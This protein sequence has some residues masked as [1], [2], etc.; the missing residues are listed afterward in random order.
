MPAPQGPAAGVSMDGT[1]GDG[2][3]SGN[4]RTVGNDIGDQA[5]PPSQ[6]PGTTAIAPIELDLS[7]NGI[8][9][10]QLTSSNTF[11]AINQDGY[12][13]RTAWAGAGDAVLFVDPNGLDTIRDANQYIFTDWD[14]SA[15]TDMQAL[16]DVFDTNHDGSLDAGDA[17]FGEFK[18]MV[19]NADGTTS[20]ETLAQAGISS[21][22]L[23]ASTVNQSFADGSSIDGETTFTRTDGSTGT[24]AAVT[25]AAD[26]QGYAVQNTTTVGADGTTTIDNRALNAD[27]SLNNDTSSATSAD[28]ATRTISYDSNGV[29]VIDHVQT[30]V[31]STDAQGDTVLT[32][33]DYDGQNQLKDST[34]TTT[35]AD[36]STVRIARDL[37]G[38]GVINQIETRQTNPDDSITD[39]LTDVNADHS[40]IDQTV[41]TSFANG[42]GRKT[43]VDSTGDG[44]FDRTTQDT[45]VVNGDGSRTE[46]ISTINAD[47][48][49]ITG[50]VIVT[51]AD[52]LTRTSSID[53]NGDLT[54]DLTRV[55]QTTDNAD[56]SVTTTTTELNGDTSVRDVTAT[57]LSAVG[58]SKTNQVDLNGD[59]TFDRTATDITATN[60]RGGQTED[61]TTTS[62]DGTL[63]SEVL[64]ARSTDGVSRNTTHYDRSGDVLSSDEIGVGPQGA[65]VENAATFGIDGTLLHHTLKETSADGLTTTT[66]TDNA[67][68]GTYDRIVV[69][70][71]IENGNGSATEVAGTRSADGTLLGR[72]VIGTSADGLTVVTRADSTGAQN[73]DG[74]G[75]FDRTTTDSTSYTN[76][77]SRHRTVTVTSANGALLSA[78]STD[79]AADRQSHSVTTD[80]N[81]DGYTTTLEQVSTAAGGA[82][83]DSITDLNPD[84]S[85]V[86]D[87][88]RTTSANGLSITTQIDASGDG[89]YN[90]TTTDNTTIGNDGL[91]REVVTNTAYDSTV[92][93]RTVMLSQANGMSSSMRVDTTGDGTFDHVTNTGKTYNTDGSTTVAVTDKAADRSTRD[94][95]V[96][97]T[98][99]DGLS[100][101][102]Q[103]D[104]DG[105]GSFD[106]TTL[107]T[108]V[109]EANGDVTK[110]TTDMNGDGSGDASAVRDRTASTMSGD[111]RSMTSQ[112]EY[113]G[114]VTFCK[115]ENNATQTNGD[116]SDT[117]ST[118]ASPDGSGA[119]L[120]T[121]AVTTSG[122][123]LSKTTQ[124]DVNG[125]GTFDT[126]ASDVTVFAA[127]GDR[128]ETMTTSGSAGMNGQTVVT[129]S[130]NGLSKTVQSDTAGNGTVD[131]TTH[132]DTT[133]NADGSRREVYQ[134]TNQDGSLRNSTTTTTS[135]D[136]KHVSVTRVLGGDGSQ[137]ET[138]DRGL[139][140]TVTDVL[141]AMDAMAMALGAETVA[142]SANGLTKTATYTDAGGNVQDTQSDTRVL[143]DDGSTTEQFS[144]VNAN[145]NITAVFS[146]NTSGNGL[147][148]TTTAQFSNLPFVNY[149]TLDTTTLNNDGTLNDTITTSNADGST[150]DQSVRTVSAD[151]L[152]ATSSLDDNADGNAE[153]T[154]TKVTATD[155]SSVRTTTIV[156]AATHA[157]DRQDIVT[158][159]ADGRT[160]TLQSARDG[161][162]TIRYTET[163]VVNPNGTISDK[164]QF[165]S[166]SAAPSYT[167]IRSQTLDTTGGQTVAISNYDAT[168]G[169]QDKTSTTVSGNGLS[170]QS[171]LDTTGDG[172]ADQIRTDDTAI[173]AD[174]SRTE[175]VS[176]TLSPNLAALLGP[177]LAYERTINASADGLTVT[178]STD[179]DGNGKS[180]KTETSVRG[181]NGSLTDTVTFND[182]TTGE[183]VMAL[184]I[185]GTQSAGIVK[186]TSA[187]GLVVS[188][189]V[190]DI[191]AQR[192]YVAGSNGSYN[193]TNS[194]TDE[195][196]SPNGRQFASASHSVDVNGVDT[197]TSSYRPDGSFG[198]VPNTTTTI[199]IDTAKEQA[200]VAEANAIYQTVLNRPMMDAEQESLIQYIQGGILDQQAL[201]KSLVGPVFFDTDFID[202][203]YANDFGHGPSAS[204]VAAY[205]NEIHQ[206]GEDRYANVAVS[207]AEKAVNEQAGNGLLQLLPGAPQA[208][209]MTV[210]LISPDTAAMTNTG[211]NYAAFVN[212]IGKPSGN[213]TPGQISQF[214]ALT[215]NTGA[216]SAPQINFA[217]A[218]SSTSGNG[219][220]VPGFFGGPSGSGAKAPGGGAAG[221]LVV[222]LGGAKVHTTDLATSSVKF[223]DTGSGTAS[224]TAWTT[225]N[226][227]FLV[228]DPNGT[229]VTNGSSMIPTFAALTNYDSNGDGILTAAEANAAGIEV[230]VDANADGVDQPGELETLGQAG[231][232]SI[233]LKDA[234]TGSY[235]HGNI[236]AADSSFTFTNGTTGDIADAWLAYGGALSQGAVYQFGDDVVTRAA[237]GTAS[238]LLYGSGETVDAGAVGLSKVVDTG[239]NNVLE[240]STGPTVTLSGSTGDQLIG[241]S[242][243]DTLLAIGDGEKVKTGTGTDRVYVSGAN[244]G[245]DASLGTST[246][247]LDG[248]G[249]SVTGATAATTV[250]VTRGTGATIAATGSKITIEGGL[251]AEISGSGNAITAAGHSTITLDAAGSSLVSDAA[252][253]VALN[254]SNDTLSLDRGSTVAVAGTGETIGL[255]SGHLTLAAGASVKVT[256]NSDG[257][258]QAGGSTLTLVGTNG[259]VDVTGTGAVTSSTTATSC[260]RTTAPMPSQGPATRWSRT[261]ARAC[262]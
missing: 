88:V 23:T 256:G 191:T 42:L 53:L 116:V 3:G 189:A 211:A 185:D 146:T 203:S 212:T 233:N 28:G 170:T 234:Q 158:T 72:T 145:A 147:V 94:Q 112:T 86:D 242:G 214:A 206:G 162:T 123:G 142:T 164:S 102:I 58:L 55:S 7:G 249:D 67:G 225:P 20:V 190:G 255:I 126:N 93:G 33:S 151:G 36:R 61:V 82:T 219:T 26:S 239:S 5:A 118:F 246:I 100:T 17:A 161:D 194:T 101:T 193:W 224:T 76:D 205:L 148:K 54:T 192:T 222:N 134:Q 129:T 9:V 27:G 260:W 59:G 150:R 173:N 85:A 184:A 50:T 207:I 124:V 71:T 216:S 80:A 15:K 34:T 45:T 232:A 186:T 254:G 121:T 181:I 13:H 12:Q 157:Q 6:D 155:G 2:T 127:N 238:E 64:T 137:L 174:G 105:N 10:T 70:Q 44:T 96:T 56:G 16:R 122:N 241:G 139:D 252:S 22:D 209:P 230:W 221:P 39:R 143:N 213:L 81:G 197:W 227:G 89:K 187:D 107:A 215:G 62:A 152:V 179:N 140:G 111:G 200:A 135:A 177:G 257:V 132:D 46:T 176:K 183:A 217:S 182:N 210:T 41:T 30:D 163:T 201:A 103:R 226:E 171:V 261:R 198:L 208:A 117:I 168:G 32:I 262:P 133:L 144:D 136:R 175:T 21:I 29:G 63:L 156:N 253:T 60:P 159:S 83:T 165:V 131:T 114:S 220:A 138:I 141:S 49:Q 231:I 35:S 109:Y 74:T 228:L 43:N 99:G 223:D 25:Y 250:D 115:T 87:A 172:T 180:E 1:S 108:T 128:T 199:Q 236:I 90:R 38:G 78:V 52:S 113:Q 47:Q 40:T 248:T 259:S 167:Q 153:I 251:G 14:P 65:T 4:G 202:T 204:D 247:S 188:T 119:P 237:D 48:T 19:T 106:R 8:A 235:D 195:G 245:V 37:T 31:T 68:D 11:E 77:G 66:R 258:R 229:A 154:D 166:D 218:S 24:V 95:T 243:A 91:R 75:I 196:Q 92:V 120:T 51:S 84:G 149:S 69:D 73:A 57:T 97:T 244:T 240:A 79:T 18:L 169:L 130:G 98:S 110:T 160:T 125:D 178:T 104:L